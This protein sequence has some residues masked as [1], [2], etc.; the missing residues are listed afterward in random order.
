VTSR[1]RGGA[2]RPPNRTDVGNT[3]QSA[4]V[5]GINDN[6]S[7]G[8]SLNDRLQGVRAVGC[9]DRIICSADRRQD[10]RSDP[11][12]D[13]LSAGPA[14][15]I[16]V[17]RPSDD[18]VASART[19]IDAS[20]SQACLRNGDVEWGSVTHTPRAPQTWPGA[21]A[22]LIAEAQHHNTPT[23]PGD[24]REQWPYWRKCL[25]QASESLDSIIL[26][27]LRRMP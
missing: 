23:A 20:Y 9:D 11:A 8:S 3:L 19:D 1:S 18:A 12:A 27:T 5:R 10:V 22:D 15:R 17:F 13:R 4:L 6:R 24:Q 21:K 25:V 16:V 14:R 2:S 26:G 7:V